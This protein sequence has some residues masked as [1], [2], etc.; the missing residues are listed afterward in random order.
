MNKGGDES[1]ASLEVG[2]LER[3]RRERKANCAGVT[4]VPKASREKDCI[5]GSTRPDVMNAATTL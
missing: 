5:Q 4:A 2:F 1:W 3:A